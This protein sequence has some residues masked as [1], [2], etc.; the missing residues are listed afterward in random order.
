MAYI[1][2]GGNDEG[3]GFE[4]AIANFAIKAVHESVGLVNLTTVVT[5]ISKISR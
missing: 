4:K 5:P 2:G 1:L 3:Y